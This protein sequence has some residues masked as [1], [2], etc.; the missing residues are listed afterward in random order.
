MSKWIVHF[1]EKAILIQFEAYKNHYIA[2]IKSLWVVP[3]G[4]L[5]FFK[6]EILPFWNEF[7]S[8]ITKESI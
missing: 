1:I 2:E 6:N 8:K 4:R 3:E 5:I 7:M